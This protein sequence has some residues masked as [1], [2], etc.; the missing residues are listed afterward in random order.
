M[1]VVSIES[2]G[3]ASI[4][5]TLAKYPAPWR[6]K[7]W[8]RERAH[9]GGEDHGICI[10]AANEATV[11]SWLDDK[12][13]PEDAVLVLICEAVNARYAAGVQVAA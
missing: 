6:V 3:R 7:A 4:P 2:A 11:M 5:A 1:Q 9:H 13:T 8:H 12:G 10:K